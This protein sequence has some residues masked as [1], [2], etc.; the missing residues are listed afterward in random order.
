M[1]Q[2]TNQTSFNP[3]LQAKFNNALQNCD[4]RELEDLLTSSSN[5]IDINQFLLLSAR[6][7]AVALVDKSMNCT[8]VK[9]LKIRDSVGRDIQCR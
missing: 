5:S 7:N 4:Y 9:N 8:Y 3:T 2:A 6:Q 1:P